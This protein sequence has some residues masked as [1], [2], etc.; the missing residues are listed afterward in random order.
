MSV[1]ERDKYSGHM[2]T[3]HEWNGIK[4]LN[5]P[6]PKVLIGFFSAAF[7]FA[8]GYWIAMPS[9]P[10]G[11]RYSKGTLEFD[12]RDF[13]DRQ[14]RVAAKQKAQ[15]SEQIEQS[16]FEEIIESPELMQVVAESGPALFGDN[17]AMCHGS[18]GEG[19]LYFPRL[20][21]EAWLWGSEAESVYQTLTV[22]INSGHAESRF[23]VMPPFG[24]AGLLDDKS[25][26]AVAHYLRSLSAIDPATT[27][28]STQSKE[29][30]QIFSLYCAGCHGTD[31]EGQPL[32]GGPRLTDGFWI[33][34]GDL[35]S[36]QA[37]VRHGRKGFMPSWDERLSVTERKVLSLY[38]LSLNQGSHQSSAQ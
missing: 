1:A 28:T 11:D 32:V 22:G 37:T 24:D 9:W 5:T 30:E 31:G 27:S 6:V 38:I 12:Q 3:G 16:G 35:E 20:N 17:C 34:G 33:Y 29:G 10:L 2:T 18:E 25:I 21:D 36:L 13:L 4:E 8:V 23:A 26:L 7:L 14:L 15:W 19:G